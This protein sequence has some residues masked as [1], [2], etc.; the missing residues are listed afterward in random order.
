MLRKVVVG[1]LV[2]ISAWLLV[3]CGRIETP[4]KETVSAVIESDGTSAE[5]ESETSSTEETIPGIYTYKYMERASFVAGPWQNAYADFLRAPANYAEEDPYHTFAFVLA[6]FNND[7]TPEL[8]L[9]YGDGVQGGTLFANVYLYDGNVRIIGQQINMYYKSCYYSTDPSFPGVFIYGGR[10]SN[11]SCNYWTI[12]DNKFVDAPLWTNIA[13]DETH[14]MVYT[15]LTGNKQLIAE[16]K[17]L[18]SDSSGVELSWLDE[19]NIQRTIYG[20]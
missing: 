1:L 20:D 2:F 19:T 15:E 13:D 4:P 18:I 16:S 17:K 11:F 6:D 5:T 3:S 7:G 10:T 8:I 12:K 9:L 14:D